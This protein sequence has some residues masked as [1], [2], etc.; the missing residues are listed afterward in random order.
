M[1]VPRS[2]PCV[3]SFTHELLHLWMDIK[4]VSVSSTL[5]NTFKTDGLLKILFKPELGDHLGNCADHYKMMK[6]YLEMGFGRDL[7]ISDFHSHKCSKTE[8]SFIERW[9][10]HPDFQSRQY[11]TEQY[12]AKYFA[13]KAC[14]NSSFDYAAE[15]FRLKTLDESLYNI[16]EFFWN[17]LDEFDITNSD[18]VF[19]SYRS[20]TYPFT[21][22]LK[23]HL[24][25]KFSP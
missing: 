11:A 12:L 16:L 21:E 20:F 25:M 3:A 23:E 2:T 9:Y 13:I 19:N 8:L 22:D 1:Y 5:S 4:D 7:F 24:A 6:P 10:N 17:K 15:L 14:P 18:P